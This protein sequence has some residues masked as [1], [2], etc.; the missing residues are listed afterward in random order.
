V[1]ALKPIDQ[2]LCVGTPVENV[3]TKGGNIENTVYVRK[4]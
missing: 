3:V 2:F 4:V 1:Q